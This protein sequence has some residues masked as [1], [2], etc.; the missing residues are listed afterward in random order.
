MSTMTKCDRLQSSRAVSVK[1]LV[2]GLSKLTVIASGKGTKPAAPARSCHRNTQAE[3][4]IRVRDGLQP[5]PQRPSANS[6]HDC[7]HKQLTSWYSTGRIHC[8]PPRSLRTTWT[9]GDPQGAPGPHETRRGAE[10]VLWGPF[11]SDSLRAD[12]PGRGLAG[13]LGLAVLVRLFSQTK[14]RGS[15]LHQDKSIF[16]TER[17]VDH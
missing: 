9:P 13:H 6:S 14:P 1:S 12:P 3:S 16:G 15:H 5:E 7:R 17:V 8:A 10:G 2:S 11:G 4:E